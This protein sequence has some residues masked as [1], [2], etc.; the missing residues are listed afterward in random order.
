MRFIPLSWPPTI[1]PPPPPPRPVLGNCHTGAPDYVGIGAP[2]A[3]S[4]WV[5]KLIAA[6]P[7]VVRQPWGKELHFFDEFYGREFTEAD[8]ERFHAYFPRAAGTVT[9]EFTP[10]YLYQPWARPLLERA[11]PD[12]LLI[13]VLRDPLEQF[14][15]SV[16]Y[17]AYH[18]APR[19]GIM[20]SRH[21]AEAAYL[22]H[23]LPWK[24]HHE[25]RLVL[26]QSEVAFKHPERELAVIWERL[27]LEPVRV[28]TQRS[29]NAARESTVQI[30][31][32]A[33]AE[34]VEYL[35]PDVLSLVATFP[36]IDLEMWPNFRHLA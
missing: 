4:S 15:S 6:H 31:E 23:L 7:G 9:G 16:N 21:M 3:G 28:A 22:S 12:A 25:D 33:R 2:R 34:L 8:V 17:S 35:T 27:G 18:G 30:T 11:A 13:V 20:V 5:N 14:V 29:R 10:G 26:I 1:A 24:H 19:N 36:Q 32:A